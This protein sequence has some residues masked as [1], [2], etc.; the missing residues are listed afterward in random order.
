[1][2]Q[3]LRIA[4]CAAAVTVALPDDA[5]ADVRGKLYVTTFA[6][7]GE[8][9]QIGFYNNSR[10]L[11]SGGVFINNG[12][13]TSSPGFFYSSWSASGVD[14]LNYQYSF[15]GFQIGTWT[16]GTGYSTSIQNPYFVG[17]S[18]RFNS[19]LSQ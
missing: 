1:M 3:F 5:S 8:R 17:F 11:W 16:F 2:Q 6:T 12:T 10:F 14:Y 19:T 18:A 9:A 7:T 13:Y 4:F 15:S